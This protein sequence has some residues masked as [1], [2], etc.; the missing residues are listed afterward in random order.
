[1]NDSERKQRKLI[2]RKTKYLGKVLGGRYKES[3]KRTEE[4][5]EQK[6]ENERKQRRT[7]HR[8]NGRKE[9]GQ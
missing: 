3:I 9:S 6:M 7:K 1:M 4:M 5:E 2:K 8:R